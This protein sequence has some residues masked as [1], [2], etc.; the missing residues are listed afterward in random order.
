LLEQWPVLTGLKHEKSTGCHGNGRLGPVESGWVGGFAQRDGQ[1]AAG[2][3]SERRP[4]LPGPID[5][6][7]LHFD[8]CRSCRQCYDVLV[9]RGLSAHL[10]IDRDG[11]IYQALDLQTALPCTGLGARVFIGR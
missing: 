1:L 8:G 4:R 3:A 9:E 11:T 10:M 2:H 6:L 5:L 7:V